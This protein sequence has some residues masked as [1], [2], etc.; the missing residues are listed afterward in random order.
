MGE[1]H[2]YAQATIDLAW[3][4]ATKEPMDSIYI[5]NRPYFVWVDCGIVFS[6]LVLRTS[7]SWMCF[8]FSVEGNEI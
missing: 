3:V 1:P 6:V 7:I 4:F 5:I 8:W 2:T